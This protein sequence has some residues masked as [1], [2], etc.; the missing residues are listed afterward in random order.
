M[1]KVFKPFSDTVKQTAQ[2]TTG[3]VKD[4]AKAIKLR[5]EETFKANNEIKD[6]MIYYY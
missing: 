3:A 5:G 6:L 4:A 2:E 1:K